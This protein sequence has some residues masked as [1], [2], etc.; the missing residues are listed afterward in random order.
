MEVLLLL[1]AASV[2][3][4]SSGVT[5]SRGRGL[6]WWGGGRGKGG[7]SLGGTVGRLR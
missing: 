6:W 1:F 4:H 5:G 2:V 3:R 7:R